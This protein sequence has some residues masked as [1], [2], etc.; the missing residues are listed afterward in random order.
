VLHR[1]ATHDVYVVEENRY[2]RT[3]A[4]G[5]EKFSEEYKWIKE[6]RS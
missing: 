5:L 6:Y 2:P 3:I 1:T 4:V